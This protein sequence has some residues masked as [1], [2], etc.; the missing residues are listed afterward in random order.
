MSITIKELDKPNLTKIKMNCDDV[1]HEKL[2]KYPMVSD[3]WSTSSFNVVVGKMGQGKTSL[4]TALVKKVFCR[5]FESIYIIIPPNSRASIDN[6]IFGKNLPEDQIHDTLTYDGLCEIYE[7]LQENSSEGYNSLLIIDDFQ[8]QLKDPKILNVLQKIITK[9]RHLR[10]TIFLLNQNFQKLEKS[11]RE[12]ISSL[13]VFNLG[14][15]QLEKIFDE[16][17]Q[18]NKDKYQE[19]TDLAFKDKH[20]WLCFNLHKSRK[21]YRNFDEIIM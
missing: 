4:V 16:V 19:L 3:C 21:I 2:T 5:C 11:L 9:M 15:S 7:K 13:L 14:K 1:I 17:I 12:L 8:S 10:V 18:I 6:D 20:D